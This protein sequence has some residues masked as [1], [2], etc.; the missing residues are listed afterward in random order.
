MSHKLTAAALL[1]T[2]LLAGC[3]DEKTRYVDQIVENPVDV[4]ELAIT[5][6]VQGFWLMDAEQHC[7][8][9]VHDRSAYGNPLLA[10]DAQLTELPALPAAGEPGQLGSTLTLDGNTRL[11]TGEDAVFSHTVLGETFTL[12][13][14]SRSSADTLETA[15]TLGSPTLGN[16]FSVQQRDDV[17]VLHFAAQ[18]RRVLVPLDGDGWQDLHLVATPERVSVS[19][20]CEPVE[21]FVPLSG[22]PL[23]SRSAT[24][25]M[26]G[27]AWQANDAPGFSGSL[28]W[29]R[30]SQAE[31]A[32]PFC[33]E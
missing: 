18:G 14:R 12:H 10:T 15:L 8:S 17:L 27:G 25:L 2:A 19:L 11:I 29:L 7:A 20:N 26:V 21:Q 23:I 9:C 4:P 32:A 31:E 13:L 28:D 30:I 22:A 33:T 16:A 5:G 1:A 3:D 24:R 6:A